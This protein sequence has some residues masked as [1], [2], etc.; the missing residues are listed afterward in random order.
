MRIGFSNVD[1]EDAVR[2]AEQRRRVV[3]DVEE[4]RHLRRGGAVQE[5]DRVGIGV[6]HPALDEVH[7]V[8]QRGD[9]A[10]LLALDDGGVGHGC[11]LPIRE[12]QQGGKK[13]YGL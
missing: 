5:D 1:L 2:V 7:L 11:V 13:R 3:V 6:R 9:P 12:I 4:Q 10:E 8:G